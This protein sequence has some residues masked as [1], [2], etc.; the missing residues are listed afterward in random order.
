VKPN[1]PLRDSR[2]QGYDNG[3]EIDEYSVKLKRLSTKLILSVIWCIYKVPIKGNT[4]K[5]MLNTSCIMHWKKDGMLMW[6][7]IDHFLGTLNENG[8]F[9]YSQADEK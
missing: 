5:L 6:L 4:K 3:R 1:V 7:V 9:T 2:K 8:N